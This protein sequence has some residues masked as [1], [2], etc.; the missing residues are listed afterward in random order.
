MIIN[1]NV[2]FLYSAL[3]TA[4]LSQ[5]ALQYFILYI[6]VY[7]KL[8]FRLLS[9]LFFFFADSWYYNIACR[10]NVEVNIPNIVQNNEFQ[11]RAIKNALTSSFSLIHG[12]PGRVILLYVKKY[13]N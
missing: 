9:L 12:P 11:K 5:S 6:I 10:T 3:I 7:S 2:R 8:I 1:N 4:E 13:F